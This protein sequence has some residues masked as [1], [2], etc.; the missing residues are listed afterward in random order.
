MDGWLELLGGIK[1]ASDWTVN[2]IH[3]VLTEHFQLKFIVEDV[4]QPLQASPG[5]A[6][7]L[8]WIYYGMGVVLWAFKF[9]GRMSL[10]LKKKREDLQG[11]R[12]VAIISVILFHFLPSI[13]PN[14][15]IGVD[16]FFVLSGY[17]MCQLLINQKKKKKKKNKE[18]SDIFIFYIRRLKRI[19]PL[20]FLILFL[21]IISIFTLFPFESIHLNVISAKNAAL[22][23]SNRPKTQDEDYFQMLLNTTTGKYKLMMIGNSWA[24]NHGT[25]VFEECG[26]KAKSLVQV[27][28]SACEALYNTTDYRC[29]HSVEMFRE[30]VKNEQPD[31]LFIFSRFINIGDPMTVSKIEDDP[32][33][34]EMMFNA[35]QLSKSVK[36]KIFIMHQ[37]PRANLTMLSEIVDQVK[38]NKDLVAFDKSLIVRDAEIARLRY[39]KLVSGCPKCEL[40]DYKPQ[41][42]NE[43]TGTWR[44]YDERNHGLTYLTQGLHLRGYL[45]R[46][47]EHILSR[48]YIETTATVILLKMSNGKRQ[49]LQGIRGVAIISVI[50][51]HFLPSIFPNGYIGVDE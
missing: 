42:F 15:Y 30:K 40:F 41:F 11:I 10:L 32:I 12:G 46:F 8:L 22:F 37:I 2:F 50:L 31:Y 4:I 19:L 5:Q 9:S 48:D 28:V 6:S 27:A 16:E 25:I 34:R 51:F 18:S 1:V 26:Y 23:I 49:D 20:Y 13:F 14:G 44:F 3:I 17:L 43:T 35:E 38:G 33:Y 29:N 24:P 21:S 45:D 39:E 36:Y 47:A 7:I